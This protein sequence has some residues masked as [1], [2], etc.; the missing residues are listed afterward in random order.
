MS[1]SMWTEDEIRYFRALL[2]WVASDEEDDSGY[3]KLPPLERHAGEFMFLVL[4][5]KG[6]GKTSLLDRFCFG[7]FAE[8]DRPSELDEQ[9]R[10][11]RHILRIEDQTYVVN[12]LE[13]PSRHL[14]SEEQLTQAVQIT[15]AVVL[16]YDVKSRGSFILL[17]DVYN[18][19]RDMIGQTRTYG[20]MLVGTNSDCEDEQREVSWAEGRKLAASFGLGC[21]FLETSAKSGDNIDRIFPQLG[22]EVLKLRWLSHQ[23][24]EEAERLSIDAR[25]RSIDVSSAKGITRWRSWTRPWFQRRVGDRKVSAPC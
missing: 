4:G 2:A 9:E 19:I 14:S 16:V 3:D 13:L 25:Q 18:H 22:R 7:T 21:A 11:Y 12:A 1:E 17:Q 8:E 15:E 24:R 10:G 6:C 23:R 20:L 5:D